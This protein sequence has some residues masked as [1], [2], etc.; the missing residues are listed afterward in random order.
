MGAEVMVRDDGGPAFPVLG[1]EL[2]DMTG[3]VV[4]SGMTLRDWYAGQ[5][6]NALVSQSHAGPK[7]WTVMGHGWGE[8]CANDLNKH[9]TV[10]ASTLAAFAFKIAD[11]LLAERNKP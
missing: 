4:T 2:T 3:A 11:A 8:D 10:V 9:S 7:D 6:I 1:R 5:A